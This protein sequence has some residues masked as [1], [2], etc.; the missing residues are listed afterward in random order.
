MSTRTV[1]LDV[2][3]GAASGSGGGDSVQAASASGG[4]GSGSGRLITVCLRRDER[5]TEQGG[6]DGG[7]LV[8]RDLEVN[9]SQ[10]YMPERQDRCCPLKHGNPLRIL[11]ENYLSSLRRFACYHGLNVGAALRDRLDKFIEFCRAELRDIDHRS[12]HS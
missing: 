11:Y 8:R 7:A 10:A 3:A 4:G 1:V 12:L 5:L 6:G 2:C 9:P